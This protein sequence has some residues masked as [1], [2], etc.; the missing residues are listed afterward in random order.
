MQVCLSTVGVAEGRSHDVCGKEWV[1]SAGEC[2]L[3]PTPEDEDA[4]VLLW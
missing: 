2:V 4:R 3:L 1:C